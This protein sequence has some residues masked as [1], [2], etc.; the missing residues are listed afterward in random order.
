MCN[1]HVQHDTLC[2][3]CVNNMNTNDNKIKN[4]DDAK[5]AFESMNTTTKNAIIANVRRDFINAS[6]KIARENATKTFNDMNKNDML[7]MI[8]TSMIVN[9]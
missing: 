4:V 1:N 8:Y 7:S 9:E 6:M 2:V 3:Q 5:R